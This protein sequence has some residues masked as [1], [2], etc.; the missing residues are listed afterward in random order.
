MYYLS[1]IHIVFVK[2]VGPQQMTTVITYSEKWN[3]NDTSTIVSQGFVKHSHIRAHKEVSYCFIIELQSGE[4]YIF[5]V[6]HLF[7]PTA[8]SAK[9]QVVTQKVRTLKEMRNQNLTFILLN[10]E[11]L[12]MQYLLTCCKSS[13]LVHLNQATVNHSLQ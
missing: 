7:L 5:I 10:V 13:V 1:E 12:H 3:L 8:E 11:S 6:S 9:H 2:T 4:T